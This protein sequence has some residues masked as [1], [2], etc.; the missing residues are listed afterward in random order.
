M[1]LIVGLGNPGNQYQDTLHNAGF[2]ALDHLAE[3]Q[4]IGPWQEKFKGLNLKA[5]L[6]GRPFLLL[7]PQT[8]MNLS[9]QSVVACL[10]FFKV[11][12]EEILVVSDDMD[13]PL[14]NLRYRQKGGHGGHNGLRNIIELLGSQNFSRLKIGIG[15]PHG[16]KQVTGHVLG[17]PKQ[18]QIQLLEEAVQ[19]AASHIKDFILGN[20]LHIEPKA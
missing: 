13:L 5:N 4:G 18:D 19:K 11:E 15:R 7:K 12:P 6:E 1:K 14:G 9:G 2:M 10:Q 17:K 3:M 20:P 8:F 16:N